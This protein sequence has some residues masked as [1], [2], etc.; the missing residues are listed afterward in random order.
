MKIPSD[1][2]G[3]AMRSAI[4]DGA[5]L[6]RPMVID[7][8][9]DCP[10]LP[11]AEAIAS[12]IPRDEFAVSIDRDGEDGAV[13]CECSKQMLLQYSEL[14]RIQRQLTD[15]ASPFGGRCEAWGTFG[16]TQNT[17]PNGSPNV[18]PTERL[19][20]SGIRGG[21]AEWATAKI[22]YEGFPLMLRRPTNLDVDS[23]RP[24]HPTLAVV[25]HKFTKRQP[26]GLPEPEYNRRLFQLD[27]ELVG[28][29]DVDRIGVPVFVETFGGKRNY[30][31]YVA[32]YADVPATISEVARRYPSE[33][34]SW[35]VRSDPNWGFLEKYTK[36]YF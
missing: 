26:N 35:I 18:S 8:Q 27:D 7:F 2:D 32:A 11:S 29:F 9:I 14:V 4:A 22:E 28:A 21:P 6:T 10:D 23:L 36:E 5:D 3:D 15:I 33:Q 1:A 24:A 31:F 19:G 25:T 20:G 34:L 12:K 13:T 17:E 30:Y 16:N